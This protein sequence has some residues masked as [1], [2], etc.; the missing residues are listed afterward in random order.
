MA[1]VGLVLLVACANVAAVLLAYAEARRR[2]I[3]LRLALGAGRI[4]LARQFLTES[5][6]LALA[7]AT[8]GWLLAVWLIGAVPALAP[9]SSVPVHY[10]FRIDLRLLLFTAASALATLLVCALAPLRYTLRLSMGEM[11]SG[12]RTAGPREAIP[13][14]LC[15][16]ERP[17]GV[18]CGARRG[19]CGVNGFSRRGPPRLPRL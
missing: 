7:G 4:A 16:G 15:A 1:L 3:G 12:A 8:A 14:A 18:L 11:I 2:E 6:L 13:A 19:N 9:P 5:A 10:D 17:G